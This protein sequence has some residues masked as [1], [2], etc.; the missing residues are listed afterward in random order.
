MGIHHT[1]APLVSKRF[2]AQ[3]S[4]WLLL[5]PVGWLGQEGM[6]SQSSSTVSFYMEGGKEGNELHCQRTHLPGGL[7]NRIPKD[8]MTVELRRQQELRAKGHWAQSAKR[9]SPRPIKPSAP[10]IHQGPERQAAKMGVLELVLQSAS[11][12]PPAKGP[13]D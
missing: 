2:S 1:T 6:W 11:V 10:S 3:I 12:T 8:G 13:H 7:A 4:Q 9:V 5:G